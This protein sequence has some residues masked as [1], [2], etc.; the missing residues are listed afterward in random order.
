VQVT[1]RPFNDRQL[2]RDLAMLCAQ[3]SAS[4]PQLPD[5]RRL[6]FTIG[7]AHRLSLDVFSQ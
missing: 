4:T 1:F 2:N 5:G 7:A 6:L 3:V